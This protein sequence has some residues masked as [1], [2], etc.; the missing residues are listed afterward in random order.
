M[1]VSLTSILDSLGKAGTRQPRPPVGMAIRSGGRT[2][3]QAVRCQ[4]GSDTDTDTDI[5]TK[6][7]MSWTSLSE[8]DGFMLWSQLLPGSALKTRNEAHWILRT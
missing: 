8:V 1:S 7:T 4:A 5:V 2:Q 6:R 3:I